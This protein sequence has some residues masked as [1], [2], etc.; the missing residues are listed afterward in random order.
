MLVGIL[1]SADQ[2]SEPVGKC[3]GSDMI[4][5]HRFQKY[6]TIVGHFSSEMQSTLR[7]SMTTSPH[8]YTQLFKMGTTDP[9]DD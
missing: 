9:K 4:H 2:R 7:C 3:L 1:D 6:F 5:Y 8:K